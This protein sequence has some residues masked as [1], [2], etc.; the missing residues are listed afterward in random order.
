MQKTKQQ[1]EKIM[2]RAKELIPKSDQEIKD[3]YFY[4]RAMMRQT[5]INITDT[6][7]LNLLKKN[8]GQN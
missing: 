6:V 1:K 2:N 5:A 3:E 4:D 8:E 7:S